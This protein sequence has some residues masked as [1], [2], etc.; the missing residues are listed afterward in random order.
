MVNW[1]LLGAVFC[2]S[3]LIIASACVLN[4]FLDQDIDGQ[5]ERNKKRPLVAGEVSGRAALLFSILLGVA[6]FSLLLTTTHPLVAIVGLV[7]YVDYVW[8]YG[9]WSKRKSIHGTLV[10]SISGATP[11]LAGYVAVSQQIDIGAVLVFT[12]LFLWQMP[13]FYSIAI[14]RL[15]EYQAAGVPVISVVKGVEATKRQILGYTVAFVLTSLL[16]TVFN[17]T[18]LAYLIVMMVAGSYWIWRGIQGL[19]SNQADVWARKMFHLALYMLLLFCLLI[20]ID[21]FLP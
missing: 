3:T 16:L 13:E 20:S 21:A 7:G 2:G 9:A 17:Y 1:W 11:I 12:V 18:G 19:Q 10:G 8:L 15:R 6:G 14:Y 4:N 5:M